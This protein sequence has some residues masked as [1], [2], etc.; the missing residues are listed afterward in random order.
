VLAVLAALLVAAVLAAGCVSMPS[1]GP[2]QSYP[3]TQQQDAQAQPYLQFQPTPP[4]VGWSPKQIVQG[5]LTAS[6]SLGDDGQVAREYLTPAAS[7]RW[8]RSW[9]ATVY[10]TSK[11]PNVSNPA[12]QSVPVPSTSSKAP[13]KKIAKQATAKDKATVTITGTVQANLSGYGSYAVPLAQDASPGVTQNPTFTLV[14]GDNG[15]WRISEYWPNLLLTNDSFE[16]DYQL[17]NL[18][19]FDP[20]GSYLVPD[21]V[22]VPV[23]ANAALMNGLVHDLINPPRDWLGY[24]ATSTAFPPGTE[25]IGD[26]TLVGDRTAEVNLRGSIAKAKKAVLEQVSG[27]LLE[28]LSGA[29][30]SGQTVKSVEVE[31]NGKQ[32][33]SDNSQDWVQLQSTFQPPTGATKDFYYLDKT[34]NL[35]RAAGLN[36]KQVRLGHLGTEFTGLAVSPD[37]KAS[38]YVAALDNSDLY[39]GAIGGKLSKRSGSGYLSISW[40]PSDELWATTSDEIV[41]VR[42][43]S[44]AN[45]PPVQVS[46]VDSNGSSDVTGPY[47]ALRVAP[48]GVRVALVVGSGQQLRFGAISQQQGARPTQV[49]YQI[50]L[51][52]FFVS[53]Q[54]NYFSSVSWYGPNDVITLADQGPAVTEYPVNGGTSVS[55]PANAQLETISASSGQPLL[56]M[57]T[58]EQIAGDLSLNSSWMALRAGSSPVYPG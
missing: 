44:P 24:G 53:T 34:G 22:Y 3:I 39:T 48:D 14:K 23:Q 43:A 18:Y 41:M 50:R 27:Q 35:V 26:V 6:A 54:D 56:A 21:P 46:V 12:Y 10:K 1:G 45:T 28:T 33:P 16:N 49:T 32:W 58:N 37:R 17:R 8:R 11:G 57:Q 30:Q 31:I 15:Q 4:G 9:S 40:D 25:L 52:P 38:K 51:S 42:A 2:V 5:F 20:T 13:G 47:T 29:G 19:F 55:I 7:K 36:G